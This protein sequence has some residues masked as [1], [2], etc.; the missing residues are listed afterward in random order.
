[1]HI[2]RALQSGKVEDAVERVNEMDPE[3]LENPALAFSMQRQQLIELIRA[4]KLDEALE[5]A[6]EY[7][8]PQGE[9]NP[10][11]L[12]DLEQTMALL[13]FDNP[14]M[15]PLGNLLS[16]EQRQKTAGDLNQ[17]ILNKQG[18]Q[19][20][21]KLPGL[22]RLLVWAQIALAEKANYPMIEDLAGGNLATTTSTT[23]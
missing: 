16:A 10:N 14:D 6:A 9:D 2:R 18:Q 23:K 4:G 7:L 22:L 15:S 17:A 3:I 1:M 20:H 12:S 13:V 5:Y 11:L 21:S 19:S 8:A